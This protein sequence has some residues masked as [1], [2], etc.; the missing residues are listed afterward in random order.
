LKKKYNLGGKTY[1]MEILSPECMRFSVDGAY[2][3][4]KVEKCDDFVWG[5]R[6]TKIKAINGV[7]GLYKALDDALEDRSGMICLA[8]AVVEYAVNNMKEY[9]KF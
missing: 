9:K 3:N 6:K 5:C 4:V 8:V 2:K 1:T 7:E